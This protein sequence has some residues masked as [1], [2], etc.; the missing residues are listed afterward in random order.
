MLR[1]VPF[2]AGSV[3]R[4]PRA[5]TATRFA[6]G[7]IDQSCMKFDASIIEGRMLAAAPGI[8]ISTGLDQFVRESYTK[9]DGPFWNTMRAG[10]SSSG[11]IAGHLMS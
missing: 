9:R 4:S 6:L 3:Q 11:P 1:G 8:S 2:F 7:E 10:P 5:C